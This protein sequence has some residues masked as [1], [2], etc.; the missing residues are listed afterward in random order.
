MGKARMHMRSYKAMLCAYILLIRSK[1]YVGMY[2]PHHH[3][4]RNPPA[5][6]GDSA[7]IAKAVRMMAMTGGWMADG[8][9]MDG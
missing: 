5:L 6:G 3:H 8:W 9:L 2:A 7:Y 4:H 1:M